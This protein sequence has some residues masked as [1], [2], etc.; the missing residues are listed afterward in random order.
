MRNAVVTITCGSRYEKIAEL[1]HPT[2]KDYAEK[3]G[4]E[5]IVWRDMGKHTIPHY[6]KLDLASLLMEYDRTLYVDSDVIIRE[7][8][9]DIFGIVQPD[10]LGLFSESRFAPRDINMVYFLIKHDVNPQLWDHRYFNT[11]VM[12]CSRAHSNLFLQPRN[13]INDFGEQTYLNMRIVMTKPKIHSLEYQWNRMSMIDQATGE[14]RH[15]CFVLHYAAG[16]GTGSES[17]LLKLIRED[18]AVWKRNAGIHRYNRNIAIVLEGGMGDQ[19]CALPT[20]RY[21][22]EKLYPGDNLIVV[23]DFKDLFHDIGLPVYGKSESV[24]NVN[25][26]RQVRSL[27]RMKGPSSFYLSQAVC[28]PVD[29]YSLQF[30]QA[31][32]PL[33]ERRMRLSVTA[34]GLQ[35]VVSK[36][37]ISRASLSGLVVLHPG[38]GRPSQ[39]FPADMWQSYLNILIENGFRVAVIGMRINERAEFVE[40]DTD[41]AGCIDL[42][43]QLSFEE[44]AAL[45]GHAKVLISNNSVP[46]HIAGAFDNWIGLIATDKHPD[47]VLPYREGQLYW[48]ARSL[49]KGKLWEKQKPVM[50]GRDEE[51]IDRCTEEEMRAVLAEPETVL[52]FVQHCFAPLKSDENSS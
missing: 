29:W 33:A 44:L 2:I 23:T 16:Y 21:F 35:S 41:K 20:I 26:Y 40:I 51:A 27:Q 48:R 5:F 13:E 46:I 30:A 47:Y 38:R 43:D 22:K 12:V 31:L 34:S 17:A 37:N 11:G 7:D 36:A 42:T 39:T 6:R 19:L 28:H 15:D 8:A 24:P 1:T 3:I 4:A 9:P 14:Q 45:I 18:L 32:L 10:C 52:D 50:V 25:E 49:E